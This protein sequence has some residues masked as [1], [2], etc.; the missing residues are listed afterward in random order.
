ML[1]AAQAQ[2][3]Q[4]PA[5]AAAA[6]HPLREVQVVMVPAEPVHLAERSSEAMARQA[7]G[8][9]EWAAA[10]E[11]AAHRLQADAQAAV[12]ADTVAAEA[13][14]RSAAAEVREEA[15]EPMAQTRQVP[16]VALAAIA[17]PQ[18]QRASAAVV[19]TVQAAAAAA[20]WC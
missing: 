10:P 16:Q 6:A 3:I 4:Q 8:L 2:H 14:D 20:M 11:M 18:A 13:Q 9:Q 17:A 19:L 7:V 5:S 12:A 1:M 15:T